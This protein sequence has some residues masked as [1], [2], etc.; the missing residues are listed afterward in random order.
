MEI[1][2][3]L[4]SPQNLEENNSSRKRKISVPLFGWKF[5]CDSLLPKTLW[6][7]YLFYFLQTRIIFPNFMKGFEV[8][9]K[10]LYCI[11]EMPSRFQYST[12]SYRSRASRRIKFWSM[13]LAADTTTNYTVPYSS[14]VSPPKRGIRFI[15]HLLVSNIYN[16]SPSSIYTLPL[17]ALFSL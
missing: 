14:I 5:Y 10:N 3:V 16:M 13:I 4:Y 12:S 7:F 11:S 17:P 15:F 8:S 2:R 6:N 1:T 9:N